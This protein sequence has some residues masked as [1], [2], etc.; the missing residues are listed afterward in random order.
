VADF[1]AYTLHGDRIVDAVSRVVLRASFNDD[2]LLAPLVCFLAD[3]DTVWHIDIDTHNIQDLKMGSDILLSHA[4]LV[5]HGL[6]QQ[7][8]TVLKV[9][10]S[11][12][13]QRLAHANLDNRQN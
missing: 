7:R 1:R 13:S 6:R 4:L 2:N 8:H 9:Q 5:L 11:V 3:S 10:K 12:D